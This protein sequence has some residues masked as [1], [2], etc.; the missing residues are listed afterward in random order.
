MESSEETSAVNLGRMLNSL[1]SQGETCVLHPCIV[2]LADCTLQHIFCVRL[3]QPGSHRRGRT[4]VLPFE[5]SPLCEKR[6]ARVFFGTSFQRG[7]VCYEHSGAYREP[8]PKMAFLFFTS[9][10]LA[11][12]PLCPE[13]V[14]CVRSLSGY[15]TDSSGRKS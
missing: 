10:H 8:E 1:R 6:T 12:V 5:I 11:P 4:A 7:N 9:F 2:L 13:I 15:Q 14:V 3:N